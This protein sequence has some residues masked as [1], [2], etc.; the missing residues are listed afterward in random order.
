MT[1]DQELVSVETVL[2][3]AH[4]AEL[5]VTPEEARELAAGLESHLRQLRRLPPGD[6]FDFRPDFTFDPRWREDTP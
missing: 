6:L 2:L 1:R 5:E 3:L 4:L